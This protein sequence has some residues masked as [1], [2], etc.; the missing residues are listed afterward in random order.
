MD[1]SDEEVLHN[2]DSFD[3]TNGFLFAAQAGEN[4]LLHLFKAEKCIE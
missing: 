2:C 1:H 4:G 3:K